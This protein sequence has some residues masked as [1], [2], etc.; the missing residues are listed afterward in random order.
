M[1]LLLLV[2]TF[3]VFPISS[4]F[5]YQ[6]KGYYCPG[7][8]TD[9]AWGSGLNAS[10]QTIYR[11]AISSWS[12]SANFTFTYNSSSSNTL[13]THYK[14]DTAEDAAIYGSMEVLDISLIGQGT[15]ILNQWAVY[16]NTANS[17]LMGSTT[18]ARSTACHELGHVVGLDDLQSGTALMNQNR[19]RSVIYTPQTDDINGK[20][21]IYGS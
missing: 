18:I 3:S 4:A 16:L 13:N 1:F 19:N 2:I 9:Y 8:K 15:L 10:W 5:A 17:N 12:S 7:A 20:I 21:A 11:N 6:T 14:A